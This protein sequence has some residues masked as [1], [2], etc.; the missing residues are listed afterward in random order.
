[1]ATKKEAGRAAAIKLKD[2]SVK[3]LGL[4]A[5][6]GDE[7]DVI[8]SSDV[9]VECRF[10][11]KT[12]TTIHSNIQKIADIGKSRADAKAAAVEQKE[13]AAS[14]KERYMQWKMDEAALDRQ[15]AALERAKK[16]ELMAIRKTE[17]DNRKMELQLKLSKRKHDKNETNSDD[18]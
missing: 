18:E 12:N 15:Q 3:K 8:S 6:Q 10:Q 1:L 9:D 5:V 17:A 16:A 7:T 14:T 11:K 13:K 4:K 2:K